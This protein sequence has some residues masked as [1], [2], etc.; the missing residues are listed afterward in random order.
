MPGMKVTLIAT[1][2]MGLEAVCAR[3]LKALGIDSTRVFDGKVE[4]EGD[5][6]D[7][8]NANL[9]LRTAGRIYIKVGEFKA[10][11]FDELFEQTQDLPWEKWIGPKDRFPVSKVTSRKSELFSK[12]TCQSIVKKAIVKRLKDAHGVSHLP[13][14]GAQCAVRIQIDKDNVTL[15]IDSSGEGLSKRGYRAHMDLAP[16]RETLAAGL[17]LLSRWRPEEDA[18]IDPMC[19]T[20]TILIEAGMIAKNIAPG[21]NR[22]FAAEKWS[23]IPK[24]L[25]A[26]ARQQAKLAIKQDVEFRIYGSDINHTALSV[27]RKNIALAGL[28]GIYV[29]KLPVQDLESRFKKGKI[30]TNPPY[31][32][33]LGDKD[34]VDALYEDFGDVVAENF[35]DWHTYIITPHQDFEELFGKKATRKRKLFNANIRCDY[36]QFY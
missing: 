24:K 34:D 4:W 15:S 27:A 10:L 36:Y 1:T 8:C 17:I 25:W 5:L 33:R 32:E 19:G 9:W 3:E 14:M 20:G 30:I 2:A 18:L 7:I 35:P 13:E 29:Q 11:T 12:S 22:S 23:C 26:N 21:L 31:G 16:I 6:T 28:D